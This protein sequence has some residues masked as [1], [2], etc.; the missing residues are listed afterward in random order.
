MARQSTKRADEASYLV[1]LE[2]KQVVAVG[3]IDLQTV[4]LKERE[5]LQQWVSEHT[6]II[7]PNLI[8]VTTEFD[9]WAVRDRPVADR[10]DVLC[11]S[12]DGC[13]VLA[14]LK[15]G[16]APDTVEMQALKYAAYCSQLTPEDLFEE[17]AR[18]HDASFEEAQEK[19]TDFAPSLGE[20]EA[21]L[22]RIRIWLLASSFDVSV[23]SAVLF[24]RD[25]KL[26]IGC[27]ELVAKNVPVA[28]PKGKPN[29]PGY[30]MVSARQIIPLPEVEDYMARRR[31]REQELE[32]KKERNRRSETSVDVL[33]EAQAIEP[34]TRLELVVEAFP[35]RQ[36]SA[37]SKLLGRQPTAGQAEW[38][39]ISQ[40]EA[41]RPKARGFSTG[42]CGGLAKEI[43]I[44]A[45]FE[46][47]SVRV[48]PLSGP[49]CWRLPSGQTVYERANELLS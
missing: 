40:K 5:D 48:Q 41:L 3:E 46:A 1:D 12:I 34:A 27:I 13:P 45:G 18:Y 14:E 6:E 38:T 43:L 21:S 42:S 35:K 36:R 23:T 19:L 44:K 49:E 20:P 31:R 16:D 37:V 26:G 33:L 2:S 39:G 4:G 11:L 10:L 17:Y 15:R 7:E 32:K 22:G 24:L 29:H 47:E 30:A 9:K 28:R 8:L 25:Y